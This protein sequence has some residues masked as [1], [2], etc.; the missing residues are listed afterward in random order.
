MQPTYQN[1]YSSKEEEKD[2][3]IITQLETQ[4]SSLLDWNKKINLPLS[5]RN[6]DYAVLG[7]ELL[8]EIRKDLSNLQ[9]LHRALIMADNFD[10]KNYKRDH[11][12]KGAVY[13]NDLIEIK[14]LSCEEP[15]EKLVND[16]RAISARLDL[17]IDNINALFPQ[18][19]YTSVRMLR[20]VRIEVNKIGYP[21]FKNQAEASYE[22]LVAQRPSLN[23][24]KIQ[25]KDKMSINYAIHT[26]FILN[27][28]RKDKNDINRYQKLDA[29]KAKRTRK[30]ILTGM[31]TTLIFLIVSISAMSWNDIT[32]DDIRDFPILGIP[33][34]ICIWAF[35]GSFAAMLQQFYQ[36]SI[37][38]FGDTLKWVLI[39]PVLG[40]VMG[41]AIYLAFSNGFGITA[42]TGN[43]SLIYLVAFFVGLS[44]KFTLG[45]IDRLQGALSN[46]VTENNP[47]DPNNTNA[48]LLALMQKQAEETKNNNANNTSIAK[49]DAVAV[50]TEI[51]EEEFRKANLA[52][53]AALAKLDAEEEFR[54]LEDGGGKGNFDDMDPETA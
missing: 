13:Q 8:T 10:E 41:S 37:Y 19:V 27:N 1:Q 42:D 15:T 34:G 26:I 33:L 49:I 39:R 9:R 48:K 7:E 29:D 44:D 53:A 51:K 45:I 20:A 23:L 4:G 6:R 12:D 17:D 16:L 11:K 35:I 2:N 18:M 43:G 22:S 5:D 54:R 50:T 31:A 38:E 36:K 52:A 3:F 32:W 24:G 30:Y 14:K 40:V 47:L 28:M 25:G 21:E 46:S